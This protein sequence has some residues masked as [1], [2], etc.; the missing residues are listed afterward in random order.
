MLRVVNHNAVLHLHG[1]NKVGWHVGSKEGVFW[2]TIAKLK[3]IGASS[4]L[5][6]VEKDDGREISVGGLFILRIQAKAILCVK[7]TPTGNHHHLHLDCWYQL[8]TWFQLLVNPDFLPDLYD[9]KSCALMGESLWY[10]LV[11]TRVLH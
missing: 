3:S 8:E 7:P 4:I 10:H 2:D 6:Q 11:H 1:N 5:V 9:W